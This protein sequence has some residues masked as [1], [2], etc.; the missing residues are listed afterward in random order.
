M[1]IEGFRISRRSL[2]ITTGNAAAL[3][4]VGHLSLFSAAAATSSSAREPSLS[5]IRYIVTDS[6]YAQSLAHAKA[7]AAPDGKTLDV[8]DG[9]TRLWQVH[10]QPLWQ[11]REGAVAGLTTRAVWQCLAEQARSHALRTRVLT[12]FADNNGHPDN[13]VSWIIA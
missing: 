4:A 10:L 13:L 11:Q 5:D 7:L 6:R 12:Q 9:L 2:L 3:A 1:G 8:T